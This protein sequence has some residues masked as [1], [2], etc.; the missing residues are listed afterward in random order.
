MYKNKSFT[1]RYSIRETLQKNIMHL[2]FIKYSYAPTY[3]EAYQI[4][5]TKKQ[6]SLNWNRLQEFNSSCTY[7]EK[8]KEKILTIIF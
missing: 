6:I 7:I 3:F 2:R 4:E 1:Q 8:K 5:R